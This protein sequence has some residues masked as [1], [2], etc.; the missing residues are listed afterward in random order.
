MALTAT[1]V[2]N[3]RRDTGDVTSPFLLEYDDMAAFF[4]QT[5][6]YEHTVVKCIRLMLDKLAAHVEMQND[7][8]QTNLIERRMKTLQDKL[9]YWEEEAGLFG[10]TFT[11]GAVTLGIDT[12]AENSDDDS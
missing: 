6:D 3:L 7:K 1:Q 11:V 10:G 5:N 8:R 4:E 12:T 2:S 9:C